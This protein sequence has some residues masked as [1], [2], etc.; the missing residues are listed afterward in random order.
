MSPGVVVVLVV[1]SGAAWE[2]TAL[3]LLGQ[4]PGIVV[5]KRCVDVDD[6]LAAASAG[7]AHV[8]VLGVDAPGLDA[9]AVDHLR[10][11]GVRPVA[12]VPGGTATDAAALRATRVGIRSLVT[13][14]K[15]A[16]LPDAVAAGEEP[17]AT[18]VRGG[19][20]ADAPDPVLGGR[21][22]AVWGPGGAP[23][24]TTVATGLAAEIA[25]RRLRTVL[26]DADP[27][28]GAVA[29]QLGILDEVSGL[30]SAA[31]V[32]AGG[33]LAERFG[34]VQR[35]VGQDLAV[36]TGLP[37]ADRWVEVR[38]GVVEHVLEVAREHA[39]VVVDT[40]FSLEQDPAAD[41]GSRP[42]RNQM[43]VGAL[44]VA[45]E[46]VVVGSADPVG[47]SRL[48]RGLVEL[49][50]VLAGAPVRVVVNRMRPTLGWPQK[51]IAGMVEGFTRL[52]GL[53]FLPDDRAAVDRAL[54]AGRTVVEVGDSPLARG[55]SEVVDGLLPETATTPAGGRAGAR[56]GGRVR[57]RTAGRARPR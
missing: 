20:P 52:T 25:R 45:D 26:V 2:S 13:E 1:A 28:G 29:Q 14:D 50:D 42:A 33:Q 36:V 32:S 10:A 12:V 4:R 53:H 17:E 55:V 37:R 3:S 47:L 21:V 15:L 19:S 48:A 16:H 7:Q 22:I 6:L 43:T 46:V 51:D 9:A 5:L 38:S 56:I 44:E 49:R 34:S 54:V 24:R 39:Q 18:V 41:F 57:R 40:G 30:L 31:R 27:Y 23:G 35:S 11:H 8:A